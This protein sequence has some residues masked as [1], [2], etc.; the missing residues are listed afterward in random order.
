MLFV[1]MMF[2]W[3]TY[4]VSGGVLAVRFKNTAIIGWAMLISGVAAAMLFL[5]P[6]LI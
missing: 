2:M 1:V 4:T 6:Y 3:L 5:L